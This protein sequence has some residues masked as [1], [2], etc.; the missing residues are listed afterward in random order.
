MGKLNNILKH[1]EETLVNVLENKVKKVEGKD[2]TLTTIGIAN[3]TVEDEDGEDRG[4]A[5]YSYYKK[6]PKDKESWL[7]Y[8]YLADFLV[9]EDKEFDVNSKDVKSVLEE[10]MNYL[11]NN[12]YLK[13]S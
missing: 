6:D 8:Y 3:V 2:Y 5:I 11:K 13:N 4:L 12:I 9:K 1:L 10:I 7:V